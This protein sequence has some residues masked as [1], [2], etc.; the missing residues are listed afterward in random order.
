MEERGTASRW[1]SPNELVAYNE[2]LFVD[3]TYIIG[4]GNTINGNG[5]LVRGNDNSG[6]GHHNCSYGRGN[7]W[8]GYDN[9]LFVVQNVITASDFDATSVDDISSGMVRRFIQRRDSIRKQVTLG[10]IPG[11][12]ILD[13]ATILEY[14]ANAAFGEA[15]IRAFRAAETTPEVPKAPPM[16]PVPDEADAKADT[17]ASDPSRECRMCMHHVAI[18]VSRPCRHVTMCSTCARVACKDVAPG[19]ATCSVCRAPIQSV[20]RIYL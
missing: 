18:C 3:F 14:R 4:S 19:T 5:N 9:E 13:D 20:E 11:R 8:Y 10:V 15:S 1:I 2:T 6:S 17:E 12:A 7:I 16:T